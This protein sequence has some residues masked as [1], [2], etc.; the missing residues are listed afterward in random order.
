MH[1]GAACRARAPTWPPRLHKADGARLSPATA[2]SY[3]LYGLVVNQLGDVTSLTLVA[4]TA[5][6]SRGR[7]KV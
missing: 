7:W 2:V 3:T 4:G 1:P 5:D 6:V